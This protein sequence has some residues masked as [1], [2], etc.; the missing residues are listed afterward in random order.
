MPFV[1][2]RY[3]SATGTPSDDGDFYYA[4]YNSVNH[5]VYIKLANVLPSGVI[6]HFDYMIYAVPE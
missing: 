3:V 2:V 1:S 4:Y 6:Y 5:N